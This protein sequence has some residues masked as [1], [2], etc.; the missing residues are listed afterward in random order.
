[1][2]GHRLVVQATARWRYVYL[3]PG[4][5][6]ELGAAAFALAN[7]EHALCEIGEALLVSVAYG[8]MPPTGAGQ[9]GTRRQ[10]VTMQ[11]IVESPGLHRAIAAEFVATVRHHNSWPRC[12]LSG[13]DAKTGQQRSMFQTS[14]GLI[15]R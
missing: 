8:S 10:T 2:A 9:R 14:A 7:H 3:S 13:T 15:Q 4:E 1:M 6:D 11:S 12:L 5:D